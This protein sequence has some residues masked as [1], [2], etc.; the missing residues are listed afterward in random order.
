MNPENLSSYLPVK[1]DKPLEYLV[2]T[3]F[4]FRWFLCRRL[5]IRKILE[6]D[7]NRSPWSEPSIIRDRI[8]NCRGVFIDVGAGVGAYA[9]IARSAK[10][11]MCF[12]PDPRCIVELKKK[13]GGRVELFPIALG[14]WNGLQKF[15]IANSILHSSLVKPTAQ[16]KTTRLV[17]VEM[18]DNYTDKIKDGEEVVVKIDTE[19]AEHLV[20]EGGRRFITRH[21]PTLILEYHNNLREIYNLLQKYGYKIIVLKQDVKAGFEHGWIVAEYADR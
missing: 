4:R 14:A 17:A 19:G 12:E 3:A 1:G 18:L 13:L 21:R 2:L 8:R 5:G 9:K 15:H 11:I 10:R 16:E 6:I 20:L 7:L